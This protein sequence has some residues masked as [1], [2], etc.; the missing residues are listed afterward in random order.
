MGIDLE[1]KQISWPLM[2]KIKDIPQAIEIYLYAEFSESSAKKRQTLND[3]QLNSDYLT[4]LDEDERQEI[5][6]SII[7]D[8]TNHLEE[9]KKIKKDLKEIITE[10]K[11]TKKLEMERIWKE[12]HFILTGEKFFSNNQIIK[13]P[14]INAILG[15]T[16]TKGESTYDYV[17]YYNPQE[18]KQ[19]TEALSTVSDERIKEI[20][21]ESG[22]FLKSD[23]ITFLLN[24]YHLLSEYYQDTS[25]KDNAMLVYL[26]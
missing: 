21:Q 14:G 25:L 3:D 1:L 22:L 4:Y 23:I 12:T 19:I 13:F 6:K 24:Q 26:T 11:K 7:R 16:I 10:G 20:I 18:V 8:L 2:K 5:W 9:Y 15:G 17:R